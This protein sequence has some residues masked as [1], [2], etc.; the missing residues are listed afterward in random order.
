MDKAT[1]YNIHMEWIERSLES[2]HLS[3][4]ENTF[5]LSIKEQLEKRGSLS[6]RQVEVLDRIYAK[7]TD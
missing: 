4:W 3:E 1:A 5:L 6:P 7:H 2:E